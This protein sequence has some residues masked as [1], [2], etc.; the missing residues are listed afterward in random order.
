VAPAEALQLNLTV[1]LA[2]TGP[3]ALTVPGLGFAGLAGAACVDT[4]PQSTA[5]VAS[6]LASQHHRR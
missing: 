3:G 2:C 5:S 4:M 6:A 1:L